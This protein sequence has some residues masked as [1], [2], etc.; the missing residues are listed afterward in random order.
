MVRAWSNRVCASPRLQAIFVGVLTTL[1]FAL[2][3]PRSV[4]SEHTPFNHFA[5]L[6]QAWSEGHW[7]LSGEPPAYAGGND[8]A[9]A[10]GRWYVTFPSFPALLIWPWVALAGGAEAVP[11]GAF[12]VLLSGLAPAG[13]C[14][15]LHRA[16]QAT[17][18]NISDEAILGWS[19]LY[20]FG[21]VYC[22]TAVQGTVWFAAHVVA[23][24]ATVFFLFASVEARRPLLAGLFLSAAMA[25]RTHLVLLGL[26][27][28]MEAYRMFARERGE[29]ED[30]LARARKRLI[31][32]G[33]PVA[34]TALWLAYHNAVRFGSVTEFGYRYLA[35]AWQAR[36]EKWGLFGFHYLGRNLGIL[37]T[38]LPYVP[39]GP[40]DVPFQINGHGLALWLTSPF[41]LWLLWPRRKTALHRSIY[42]ALPLAMLPSLLY[43]NSGWLQFGQR[44]SNDY[45]P[46]LFLLLALSGYAWSRWLKAVCIGAVVVNLFGAITFGRAEWSRYYYIERTQ[47]VIY[48]PD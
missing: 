18:A 24:A 39:A 33:L 2:L 41:Y 35:V 13:L 36:I 25:T 21:S 47:R 3:A 4:W 16:R 26:F 27:F 20:A 29:H 12:F 31:W 43:Q 11:D 8:F 34:A 42:L 10:N 32:F 40:S 48:Q 5:L 37:L 28:A 7:H 14:L 45:A 30:Y 23:A 38:S 19:L 17:N 1:V 15:L 44:F 9:L 6:A 22:F 46:L